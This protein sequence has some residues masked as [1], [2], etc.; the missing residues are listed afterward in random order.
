MN[1]I[2]TSKIGRTFSMTPEA[3]T[4]E[5][6]SLMQTEMSVNGM[7]FYSNILK[8]IQCAGIMSWETLAQAAHR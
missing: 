3:A 1:H 5:D 4:Q 7:Q 8:Q 6:H 2:E